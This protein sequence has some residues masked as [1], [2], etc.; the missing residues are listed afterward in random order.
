M[1]SNGARES[2]EMSMFLGLKRLEK[3]GLKR[4]Q[5]L[6]LFQVHGYKRVYCI[7]YKVDRYGIFYTTPD[8][9]EGFL[10]ISQI[11]GYQVSGIAEEEEKEA[12][13]DDA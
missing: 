11:G 4:G 6:E 2:Q 5:V 1:D 12:K 10:R 13:K 7:D 8:G 9:N 3:K